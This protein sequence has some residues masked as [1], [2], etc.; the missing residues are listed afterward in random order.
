MQN[1]LSANVEFDFEAGLIDDA[2]MQLKIVNGS[3]E[4]EIKNFSNGLNTVLLTVQFP[5]TVLI[6]VSGKGNNDTKVDN[7]GNI[8]ADKYLKLVDVRVDKLSVD[9]HYL[10]RFIEIKIESNEKITTN[11]F[12]FNG[13][14]A[15]DFAPTPFKWLAGTKKI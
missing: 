14:V 3:E 13:T 5:Q 9:P 6:T 2:S 7:N 12:G 11:Y 10:P 4:V 1:L 15:I 8:I